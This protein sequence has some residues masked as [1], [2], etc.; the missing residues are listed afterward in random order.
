MGLYDGE[1][2]DLHFAALLRDVGMLKIPAAHQGDPKYFR[3]HPAVGS[4]ML[5][6]IRLWEK[7]SP[8]VQG[9]HERPDATGYPSGVGR[10]DEICLGARMLAVCDAW[11]AM[12]TDD[13]HRSA[14][15]VDEALEELAAHVGT[16][17]DANV[18]STLTAL[19]Q[20]G[21]L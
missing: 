4:K 15:P 19:A 5:S 20:E 18:V 1:L 16:Q 9:H 12:Q 6:R 11:D 21:V 10:G 13:F 17:F 7:A 14:I 2:H 8:I 3:K